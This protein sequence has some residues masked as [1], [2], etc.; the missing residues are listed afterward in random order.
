MNK[1]EVSEIKKLFNPAN[2]CIDLIRC[3]YVNHDGE[4]IMSS[5]DR[6]LSLH[7]EEEFKYFEVFKNTL[8]GKLGKTLINLDFPLE[9]EKNGECYS[10]LY[11]LYDT[12][13]SDDKMFDEMCDSIIKNYYLSDCDEYLIVMIHCAYDIPSKGSDNMKMDDASDDVYSFILCALCPMKLSAPGLSYNASKPCIENDIRKRIVMPPEHGFLFPAFNDR[14][15]DIHSMLYFSKK[16]VDLRPDMI[17]NLF[18]C[19]CPLS[20]KEQEDAFGIILDNTAGNFINYENAAD[21]N[22]KLNTLLEE[23]TISG[24]SDVIE[25]NE[26]K[27][28]LCDIGVSEDDYDKAYDDTMPSGKELSLSNITDTGTVTIETDS[29]TVIKTDASNIGTEITTRMIDGRACIVIETGGSI[30]FNGF[31]VK[32]V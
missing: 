11:K 2:C 19:V 9:E 29:D 26:L 21:I 5:K 4:K 3:C 27:N 14:N 23:R 24:K 1:R 20:S 6:F 10:L 18:G 22:K 32:T 7:D 25:K 12:E 16:A 17:K 30:K 13:L 15:T 31:P 28:I 8:K